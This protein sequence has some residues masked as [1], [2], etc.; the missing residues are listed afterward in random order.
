MHTNTLSFTVLL[1]FFAFVLGISPT[2]SQPVCL[3]DGSSFFQYMFI[4]TGKILKITSE[5]KPYFITATDERQRERD[6]Q[7]DRD[8]ERAG[9][10]QS[11]CSR[12][13]WFLHHTL[14]A[15]SACWDRRRCRPAL[16]RRTGSPPTGV[17]KTG[18]PAHPASLDH[19]DAQQSKGTL[20]Q[21]HSTF[22]FDTQSWPVSS[23]PGLIFKDAQSWPVFSHYHYH[24]KMLCWNTVFR[25][26]CVVDMT[27]KSSYQL[28]VETDLLMT[29]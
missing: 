6:R 9:H 13:P 18:G 10:L 28:I 20:S 19:P 2:K 16:W 27:S 23:Q 1:P 11:R 14:A 8:T 15:P 26:P 24:S 12:C 21:Q 25:W 17:C 7:T 22:T 5:H 3:T 29:P 4:I